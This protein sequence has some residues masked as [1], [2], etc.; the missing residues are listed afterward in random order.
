MPE[1]IYVPHHNLLFRLE[2]HFVP[3]VAHVP[4]IFVPFIYNITNA[5][6]RKYVVHVVQ[7]VQTALRAAR[8]G[9]SKRPYVV[10]TRYKSGSKV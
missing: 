9:K 5:I 10:H 1:P 6:V 8:V 2:A 3:G 7:V 4:Y